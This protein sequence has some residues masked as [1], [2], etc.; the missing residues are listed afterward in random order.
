MT[1]IAKMIAELRVLVGYL[2]EKH[3][4]EWWASEFYS[5]TAAAF[6]APIFNRSLFQAQYQGATAAAAKA[7]DE[8]IGVGRIFHLFRLPIGH[9][10]AAADSLLDEGFVQGIQAHLQNRDRALSRLAQLAKKPEDAEAG[11][12]AVGE[13]ADDLTPLLQR[14]AAL[15]HSAFSVGIKTFPFIR[16]VG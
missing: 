5:P 12:M 7:H 15:Y 2:G 11:P 3:Q 10:Q 9:E 13:M 4:A 8:T 16:E 1:H 6:L 14:S